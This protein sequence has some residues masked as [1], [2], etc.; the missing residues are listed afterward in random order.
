MHLSEAIRK[1]IGWCPCA[2]EFRTDVTGLP[3]PMVTVNS[4]GPDGGAG[5]PGR[6][7]RGFGL[8]TGSIKI[9][10]RNRRLLGFSLLTGLVLIVSIAANLYLQFISGTALFPGTDLPGSSPATLIAKGSL[11]WAVLTF[12]I[13]LIST[14]LTYYLLAGLISC[15]S[16]ILRHTKVTLREGLAIAGNHR[17]SL[18]VWAAL[19]A[20]IGTALTY[21]MESYA[22]NFPIIIASM[23]A[24]IVFFVI[25]MFVIPAVVLDNSDLIPAIRGSASVFRKVWGETIACFF[26]FFLIAFVI[27]LVAMV[28]IAAI[29]FSAG[30]TAMISVIVILYLLVL[31]VL[32]FIGSTILGIA[33]LGLYTYGKTGTMDPAFEQTTVGGTRI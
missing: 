30:G 2:Q 21:V 1:R 23:V 25:T 19:G 29:G 13:G 3:A 10:I 14:F 27:Y 26:I 31:L 33:T 28:P 12:G 24:G 4:P 7:R 16:G 5:R 8:A 17:Q 20:L 6:I 11:V 32:L 18:A 22:M 9:L 15:V